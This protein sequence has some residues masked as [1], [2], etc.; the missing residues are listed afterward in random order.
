MQSR[1]IQPLAAVDWVIAPVRRVKA[2]NPGRRGQPARVRSHRG[3][4]DAPPAAPIPAPAPVTGAAR[5]AETAPIS[6]T[7][8]SGIAARRVLGGR[9]GLLGDIDRGRSIRRKTV[10]ADSGRVF[11]RD[12]RAADDNLDGRQPRRVDRIHDLP[13][14]DHRRR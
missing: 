14:P 8:E 1:A 6:S 2:A 3:Q 13:H 10:R 5:S 11:L 9:D 12:R 7:R 4:G